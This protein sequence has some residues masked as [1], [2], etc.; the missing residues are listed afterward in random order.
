MHDRFCPRCGKA[1]RD[2]DCE[3]Q[4]KYGF[5]MQLRCGD[6]HVPTE[7]SGSVFV[8][9]AVILIVVGGFIMLERP[10]TAIAGGLLVFSAIRFIRQYFAWKKYRRWV[11]ELS[12]NQ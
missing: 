5:V 2:S 12:N 7:Y 3:K 8:V 9:I 11:A 10:F 6:C 4:T 1:L